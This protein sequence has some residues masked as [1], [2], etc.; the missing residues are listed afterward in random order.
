M[1]L[2][3]FLKPATELAGNLLDRFWPEKLDEKERAAKVLEIAQM[4]ESRDDTLIKAQRDVIVAELEQGDAFTK[5]ARPWIVYAGL[6]MIAVNHVL[7]PFVNRIVEWVALGRD[8]DPAIFAQLSPVDLPAEFWT[9][10]AGVVGIYAIGR[11][12]EKRG[13]RN[14]II[15]WITGNKGLHE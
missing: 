15:K 8:V 9:A 2:L 4:I 1:P 5:R 12:A 14:D 6:I 7:I 3:D 13:A 11:T 10:W